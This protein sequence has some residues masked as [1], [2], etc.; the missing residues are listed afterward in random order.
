MRPVWDTSKTSFFFSFSSFWGSRKQWA[1]KGRF[2]IRFID[3][4]TLRLMLVL[5]LVLV[6]WGLTACVRRQQPHG[7]LIVARRVNIVA[8]LNAPIIPANPLAHLG[9]PSGTIGGQAEVERVI[10]VILMLMMLICC[11]GVHRAGV[12][13]SCIGVGCGVGGIRRIWVR[14][15]ICRSA[16]CITV[17]TAVT[18]V[19]MVVAFAVAW[20]RCFLRVI[21]HVAVVAAV[22]GMDGRLERH[23]VCAPSVQPFMW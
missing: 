6:L 16:V 14:R 15:R 4:G 17:P 13:A 3:S 19:V 21:V 23:Y 5:V 7:R 18:A 20:R 2:H 10:V 12:V 1:M 11:G 9:T 22:G 8:I